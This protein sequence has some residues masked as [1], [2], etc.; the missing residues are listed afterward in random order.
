MLPTISRDD[1]GKEHNR[2]KKLKHYNVKVNLSDM[3][4]QD[5]EEEKLA[6]FAE[7]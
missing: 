2:D 5:Q 1:F 3:L 6:N 7:S 4:F